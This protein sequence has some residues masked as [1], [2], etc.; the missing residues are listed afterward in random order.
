MPCFSQ[1]SPDDGRCA[2]HNGLTE[3]QKPIESALPRRPEPTDAQAALTCPCGR[4]L[5]DPTLASDKFSIT[6]DLLGLQHRILQRLR[7]GASPSTPEVDEVLAGGGMALFGAQAV[8]HSRRLLLARP[9]YRRCL[10]RTTRDS[11]RQRHL[12]R[13]PSQMTSRDQSILEPA[14]VSNCHLPSTAAS[15]PP[16]GETR[17]LTC[18]S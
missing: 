11:D 4:R 5:D 6:A 15:V 12:P 10:R 16:P 18:W 13:C 9:P 17:A 8:H 7:T 2:V 14:A 1:H 3:L